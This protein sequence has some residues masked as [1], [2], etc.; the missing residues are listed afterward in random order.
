MLWVWRLQTWLGAVTTAAGAAIGMV[1]GAVLGGGAGMAIRL[2]GVAGKGFLKQKCSI[3]PA[4][5]LRQVAHLA[6]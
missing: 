5:V 4:R 2:K 6:Q 3:K 1:G